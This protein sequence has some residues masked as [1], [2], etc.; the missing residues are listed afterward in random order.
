MKVVRQKIRNRYV[1][2]GDAEKYKDCINICSFV[3][4][5]RNLDMVCDYYV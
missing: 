3:D 5:I 1:K 4:R 2:G